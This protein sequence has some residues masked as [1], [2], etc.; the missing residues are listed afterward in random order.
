MQIRHSFVLNS[1]T[2]IFRVRLVFPQNYVH[3]LNK[4]N[5]INMNR[6]S[7]SVMLLVGIAALSCREQDKAAIPVFLLKEA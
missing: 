4:L 6:I 3:L 2:K 1:L 7:L 5:L